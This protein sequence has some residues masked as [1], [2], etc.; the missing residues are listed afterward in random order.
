M[1]DSASDSD[2]I[3][4][5]DQVHPV[6]VFAQITSVF[7]STEANKGG[8]GGE[9]KPETLTAVLYPHR[10]IR[11]DEL[12]TN[13]PA[14]TGEEA[15]PTMANVVEVEPKEKEN[16]VPSFEEKIP[17]VE[18]VKEDL[19][20]AVESKSGMYCGLGDSRLS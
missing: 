4:S 17:S 14:P 5:M 3:T 11:I 6:G 12:V 16:D 18:E 19:G 10:R 2:V 20:S 13:V 15:M 9:S 7:G 1:K 8:E